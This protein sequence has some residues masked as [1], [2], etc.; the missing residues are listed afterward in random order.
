MEAS[1]AITLEKSVTAV[2]EYLSASSR[3]DCSPGPGRIA[4]SGCASARGSTIERNGRSR[5]D[6]VDAT[7]SSDAKRSDRSR[8][9]RL[10]SAR[11]ETEVKVRQSSAALGECT[12][13]CSRDHTDWYTSANAPRF[14]VLSPGYRRATEYERQ[15]DRYGR[16]IGGRNLVSIGTA[17]EDQSIWPSRR[18]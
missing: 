5:F 7:G 1:D 13:T 2:V 4:T 12:V 6:T 14:A 10:A 15:R 17:T 9:H 18:S 16:P 11:W 3:S 8:K